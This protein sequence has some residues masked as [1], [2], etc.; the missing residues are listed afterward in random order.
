MSGP[1]A[2]LQKLQGWDM[3]PFPV[4]GRLHD[5]DATICHDS[6]NPLHRFKPITNSTTLR[7]RKLKPPFMFVFKRIPLPPKK[8]EKQPQQIR[9]NPGTG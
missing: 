7:S 5:C 3:K 9:D 8:R 6:R 1:E 2:R 4:A